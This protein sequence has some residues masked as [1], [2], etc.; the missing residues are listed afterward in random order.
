VSGDPIN[1]SILREYDI[2]GV[3]GE[4]LLA[5]DVERIGR[6]FG[7]I[8]ADKFGAGRTVCVGY[9]GRLSSPELAENL[10]VGLASTGTQVLVIEQGPTPLLYFATTMQ[11]AAGGMMITGSHNPP[12]Y[13]GIKMM[14]GGKSFFGDDIQEIGRRI[15]QGDYVEGEGS[16]GMLPMVAAYESRLLQSFDPGKE[17]NVAWDPGNGATGDIVQSLIEKLSGAHHLINGEVDGTFPN[18]HPDPTVEKNLVQLKALVAEN[19]CDLGIGFD[20][21]GDRIGVIDSQGRVLWG[22]QL[23]VIWARDVLSRLPGSPI[24]ADVKASKVFYDEVEKAGGDAIMWKTGHSLI[25]SRMAELKAPLAGEMSGH[26]FFADDY[27]GF[28]DALYAAIRLLNILGHSDQNLDQ[29]RDALPQMVNTPE[30]RFD[31]PDERKFSLVEE[32]KARLAA[33]PAIKVNTIDGVRVDTDDGWWLLRASNTQPVLVV[34]CESDSDAGLDRLKALVVEQL[35]LSGMDAPD[36][37]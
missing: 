9:D 33:D 10:I 34:R 22:D 19:K 2:R 18:H 23:M 31:C 32:V 17:L 25:K 14:L 12:D 11:K 20:G 15:A 26:I 24:I 37:G 3:V 4:T 21:D 30:V 13:N 35:A 6:A 36:F 8:V 5:E 29:M 16:V 28:D 27:Y 7:S 1:P